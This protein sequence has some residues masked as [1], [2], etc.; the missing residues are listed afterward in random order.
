MLRASNLETSP[1]EFML[2]DK[3]LCKYAKIDE[4]KDFCEVEENVYGDDYKLRLQCYGR[5]KKLAY[6]G[7][8][9]RRG[10]PIYEGYIVRAKYE[11][12]GKKYETI[13]A[14]GFER[15]SFVI[16]EGD[17][18]TSLLSAYESNELEII[19][20][21]FSSPELLEAVR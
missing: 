15:G 6:T 11:I 12:A 5:F 1:V 14:I 13:G 18:D 21:I 4:V 19:G 2:Y 3:D 20:N 17:N 7:I 9:D 8:N 16:V 10:R